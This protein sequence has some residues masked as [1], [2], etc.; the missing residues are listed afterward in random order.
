MPTRE[1]R[2]AC[3]KRF[4]VL[5]SKLKGWER[6]LL[7]EC[8]EE[9]TLPI[10]QWQW[11]M[12]ELL[13]KRHLK[14]GDRFQLTLFLLQNMIPPVLIAKWMIKRKMLKH[15]HS[16]KHVAYIIKN[17][18]EGRLEDAGFT[19][20][21]LNATD[22]AGNSLPLRAQYQTV[23]TPNFAHDWQHQHFWEEAIEMLKQNAVDVEPIPPHRQNAA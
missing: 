16:R 4:E 3:R 7:K 9:H 17:H 18:M 19:A 10:K 2:N 22:G 8:I 20:Q 21:M 23:W 15:P 6:K 13:L 14:F 5:A 11:E 12:A 1:E